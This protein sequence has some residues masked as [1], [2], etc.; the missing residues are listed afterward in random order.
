M[1]R[2][3]HRIL[4]PPPS[5]PLRLHERNPPSFRF[6]LPFL[7]RCGFFWWKLGLWTLTQRTPNEPPRHL[8]SFLRL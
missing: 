1:A 2:N 6:A 8:R 7:D 3:Q 4:D 5:M